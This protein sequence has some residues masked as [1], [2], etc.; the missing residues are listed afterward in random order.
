MD[1]SVSDSDYK[2]PYTSFPSSNHGDKTM[3]KSTFKFGDAVKLWHA[4]TPYIYV[5]VASPEDTISSK[6]CAYL[7]AEGGRA[8][9]CWP[10]EDLSHGWYED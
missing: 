6:P 1:F 4:S 7:I 8:V 2:V 10:I 3:N 5:G 9:E